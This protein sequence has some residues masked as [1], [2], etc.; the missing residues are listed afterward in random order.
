[1]DRLRHD[2]MSRWRDQPLASTMKGRIPEG[3]RCSERGNDEFEEMVREKLFLFLLLL[4][5]CP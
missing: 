5:V 4:T 3:K 1:V 2:V